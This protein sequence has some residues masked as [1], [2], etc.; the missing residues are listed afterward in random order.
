M[1]HF[2]NSNRFRFIL[3]T[4][5]LG[6]AVSNVIAS[7][8]TRKIGEF[9]GI[10]AGNSYSIEYKAGAAPSLVI[11]GPT[12][13]VR[14]TKVTIR[15]GVLSLSLPAE[16]ANRGD[17]VPG[18][19]NKVVVRITS[20]SLKKVELEGAASL[21][22][23]GV[24]A[25]RFE[26]EISGGSRAR[27][28]GKVDSLS[29]YASGSAS[30]TVGELQGGSLKANLDG[31]TQVAIRGSVRSLNLTLTGASAWLRG[32]VTGGEAVVSA[33]GASRVSG[34]TGTSNKLR[35]VASGASTIDLS[36][37][38]SKVAD[39]YTEGSAQARVR[40][41]DSVTAKANGASGI[42]VLGNPTN[43]KRSSSGSS[44]ITVRG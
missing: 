29:L 3:V 8:E 6:A 38:E 36:N 24:V 17:S 21:D 30:A 4:A 5:V 32:N 31:S 19:Q 42:Q 34:I 43:V 35:V 33:D 2:V 44:S 18:R 22:A 41:K 25:S 9:S 10:K 26:L 28:A 27:I 23:V 1:Q 12:E 7:T 16:M 11:D 40:T 13:L 39:V 15:G 37:L 14:A 20:A